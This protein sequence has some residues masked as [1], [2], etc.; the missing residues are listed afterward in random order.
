M[1]FENTSELLSCYHNKALLAVVV[2][3]TIIITTISRRIP[4]T[5]AQHMHFLEHSKCYL[6]FFNFFYPFSI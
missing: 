2:V 6:A 1:N 4:I 3:T 5:I